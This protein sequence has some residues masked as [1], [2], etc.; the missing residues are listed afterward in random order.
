MRSSSRARSDCPFWGMLSPYAHGLIADDSDKLW[1]P[2]VGGYALAILLV[3]TAF[4]GPTPRRHVSGD[5]YTNVSGSA[6]GTR[7]LYPRIDA[8]KFANKD[9]DYH[10]LTPPQYAMPSSPKEHFLR[11]NIGCAPMCERDR[12][13][14]MDSRRFSAELQKKATDK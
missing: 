10:H 5:G 7:H 6:S 4:Y 14:H 11:L 9:H 2:L 13:V 1:I 3:C 12:I 8:T